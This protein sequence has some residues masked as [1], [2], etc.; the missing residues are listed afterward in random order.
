M[1][2]GKKKKPTGMTGG[3]PRKRKGKAPSKILWELCKQLTRAKYGNTCYTCSRHP[4]EGSNWHTGHFIP[5]SVCSTELGYDLLNLRPQCYHCNI[6]LSGNWL[7]FEER[8]TRE[9][10]RMFVAELKKRNLETKGKSYGSTWYLQKIE[11]YQVLV[12][13]LSKEE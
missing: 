3:K 1:S 8:L 2:F 4:L 9:K 13:N 7:A 6:N 10:G 5:K 12:D 11:E